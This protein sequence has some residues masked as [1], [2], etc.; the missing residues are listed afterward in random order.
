[1][2]ISA[3]GGSSWT[4]PRRPLAVLGDFYRYRFIAFVSSNPV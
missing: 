4:A 2:R 3:M 1:L